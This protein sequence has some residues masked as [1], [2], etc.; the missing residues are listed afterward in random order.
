MAD[1]AKHYSA[2][3]HSDPVPAAYPPGIIGAFQA[4]NQVQ[5]LTGGGPNFSTSL[6]N[7]KIYTD[8]F[9]GRMFGYAIAEVWVLFVIIMIFTVISYRYSNRF[10][11]YES[12]K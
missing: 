12:D 11:Y 2:H 5:V 3:D 7:Y 1:V 8:A 6:L 9:N 4:F 10:V